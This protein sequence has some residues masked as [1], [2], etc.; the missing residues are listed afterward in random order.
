MS[1]NIRRKSA[2]SRKNGGARPPRRE[3]VRCCE[4][5]RVV[6][7]PST[8]HAAV[9]S[10]AASTGEFVQTFT[11]ATLRANEAIREA[12]QRLLSRA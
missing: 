12:E 1:K 9:K 3:A 8:L 2:A 5:L 4:R 6:V 11:A 10:V 7:I